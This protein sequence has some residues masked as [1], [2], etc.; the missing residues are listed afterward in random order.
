MFS[1]NVNIDLGSANIR[2]NIDGKTV[3][4][5]PSLVAFDCNSGAIKSVGNKAMELLGK[6]LQGITSTYPVGNGRVREFALTEALLR[7]YLRQLRGLR[8]L[9]AKVVVPSC[10]TSADKVCWSQLLSSLGLTSCEFIKAP[11][12]IA[13]GAKVD[14]SLPGG[15]RVVDI[16][17]GK[18]DIAVLS[19][20]EIIVSGTTLTAGNDFSREIAR[21]LRRQ[22]NMAVSSTTLEELKRSVATAVPLEAPKEMKING[23]DLVSGQPCERLISSAVVTPALSRPLNDL[24]RAIQDVMLET[25]CEL[26][27]DLVDNGILLAGGSTGMLGLGQFL[28]DHFSIPVR[29]AEQPQYC[30]VQGCSMA[31]PSQFEKAGKIF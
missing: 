25:P 6:P 28:K 15:I 7:F 16:G 29:I 3:V 27:A 24:A 11:L 4:D 26:S 14:M 18:T 9:K 8:K 10:L 30:A 31:S 13:I 20:E 23:F 2:L 19:Q 22:Y 21:V 1:R 12:A 17:A 5:E